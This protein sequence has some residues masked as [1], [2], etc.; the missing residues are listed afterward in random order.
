MV[1]AAIA[2]WEMTSVKGRLGQKPK[3]LGP[4]ARISK[5]KMVVLGR[6]DKMNREV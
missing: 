6:I 4:A 2:R 5:E 1:A 3:K